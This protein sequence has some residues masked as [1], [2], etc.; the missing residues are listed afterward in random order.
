MLKDY[1]QHLSNII[2]KLDPN[3]K[4]F[5]GYLV[6]YCYIAHK[7]DC[8]KTIEN[9]RKLLENVAIE[10]IQDYL[11]IFCKSENIDTLKYYLDF[12]CVLKYSGPFVLALMFGKIKFYNLKPIIKNNGY[13]Y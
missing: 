6:E 2:D 5:V 3:A 8:K 9:I 7:N 11:L 4:N 13:I 1:D 12:E 10:N